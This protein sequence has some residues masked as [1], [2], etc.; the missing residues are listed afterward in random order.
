[1][2]DLT[3]LRRR[4]ARLFE[5][6][7]QKA[8]PAPGATPF[9]MAAAPARRA[10]PRRRFS[11]F[12]PE[13]AQE[14]AGL[15]AALSLAAWGQ[16]TEE[17]GL[18][19]ALDLAEGAA[20]AEDP[21]L[22]DHALALFVTHD[23]RGRK[24][25]KPRPPA[26][27]LSRFAPSTP[28]PARRRAAEPF[29]VAP[30]AALAPTEADL[31]F[32]R[33]DILA[34]EH[35]QHWHEVYPTAGLPPEDWSAWAAA[36]DLAV[37]VE[38]FT[39][40]DDS[41]DWEPILAGAS[42]EAIANAL[43]N[44]SSNLIQQGRWRG[45]LRSL[46][47]GAYAALMRLNHRHGELFVYMHQQMLARYD[48]ERLSYGLER[49]TP[50]ADLTLPIPDTYSPPAWLA[51][52]GFRER[53]SGETIDAAGAAQLAGWRQAIADA[54]DPAVGNGRFLTADGGSVAIDRE[55][56]GRVAEAVADA[57]RVPL[58][59]TLYG[60][61]H[62]LGH[63]AISGLSQANDDGDR[64]GV[65]ASTATAIRDPVFWRWHKGI[66]DAGF[67]WQETRPAYDWNAEALAAT[68]R[69]SLDPAA[70][71]GGW[72]S[73]DLILC[74]LEDLPGHEAPDFLAA[75]GPALGE[76][77]FGGAAWDLDFGDAEVELA[78]GSRFRTVA[79]LPTERRSA[80]IAVPAVGGEGPWTVAV[81]YLAHP[82]F[83]YFLRV[84]NSGGADLP[85]TVRVFLAPESLA[86]DR[87]AWIEMDKFSTVLPAG[88]RT[89]LFRA[90]EESAVVKKPVD[91]GLEPSPG[92]GEAYCDCGWPYRLL[93]PSGTEEGM[94]FR[95]LVFLSDGNRDQ[96]AK[97][98]RCGSMSYC[99]ARDRYPDERDMGFPF[100]RPFPAGIEQDLLALPN[101]AGR[102]L[103]IRRVTVA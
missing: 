52:E 51:V 8:A 38:I 66:D 27:A 54:T 35:H 70:P 18:G 72:A 77:A 59:V 22:V 100:S 83:C 42:R 46:S 61:W 99:G 36:A 7:G 53:L 90:D 55:N 86:G 14:A 80:E 50:L 71:R 41:R 34:N 16:E 87:R 44:A 82:R 103:T 17:E 15:A 28:A 20:Q 21:E 96:V 89:V 9:G 10:A 64:V 32:W 88:K 26:V 74:R 84:E 65:M 37:L 98:G 79:E 5:S 101:A 73:P 102:S 4:S 93:L 29:A 25:E 91:R 63:V 12:D 81:S 47:A 39:V 48:A 13:Q 1:M 57:F 76:V 56:L 69:T 33:E 78:D 30:A 92:A 94:P 97:P 24:L 95:L 67:A 31:A 60:N 85:V 45:F 62:N 49:V 40:L 11:S 3:D 2:A 68:V 58:D 43:R 23:R 75:G 6:L 19:S